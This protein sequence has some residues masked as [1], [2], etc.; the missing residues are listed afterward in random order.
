M[1]NILNLFKHKPNTPVQQIPTEMKSIVEPEPYVA[2]EI[3][4]YGTTTQ[5]E[6]PFIDPMA[7]IYE[8][9]KENMVFTMLDAPPL[10]TID[11]I[12][13]ST[14][15]G[16]SQ[17]NFNDTTTYFNSVAIL[18]S[19]NVGV[20]ALNTLT[21]AL[22]LTSSDLNTLSIDTFSANGTIVLNVPTIN[23]GV[24]KLNNLLGDL[25]LL[26]SNVSTLTIDPY[27]ANGTIVF[28]VPSTV[29]NTGVDTVNNLLG[30]LT[31]LSSNVS[32]L[33]VDSYPANSTI[34]FH[35]PSTV[36]NTG[37]DT[38]NNLL[39]DLTLLSSNVSTLT[40]DSYSANSTIVFHV[41]STVVNTG[42]DTINNI[43][44][45]I[46]LLSANVSTLSIDT[47]SANSTIVLKVPSATILPNDDWANYPA[48]NDV[49]IPNHDL[50]MT[51][52]TAGVS[53][54]TASFN[55]NFVIG[56]PSNLPLRPDMTAY[57]GTVT[58]GGLTTP[59]TGMNINSLGTVNINSL[60]GLSLLGGGGIT[61]AGAGAISA[62]GSTITLGAGA[63]SALG[64]SVDL[65]G[66]AINMAGGTINMA[67]GIINALGTAVN[68]GGGLITATTGGLLVTAGSVVVGTANIAGAGMVCYGGEIQTFP[69]LTGGGGGL[70]MNSCPITGVTTINGAAYP[71]AIGASYRGAWV[72]GTNYSIDDVVGNAS[73]NDNNALNVL[74][75]APVNIPNSVN[76]P[77]TAAG[78]TDGWI[79]YANQAIYGFNSG[80]SISDPN[81]TTQINM[82][83]IQGCPPPTSND[84][85]FIFSVLNNN[86]DIYSDFGAGRYIVAGINSGLTPVAGNTLP[87]I[88][89]TS[90]SLTDYNLEINSGGSNYEIN[91]I[92]KD[93]KLNG[94]PFDIGVS[95]FNTAT[96]AIDL[97]AADGIDIQPITS[98]SFGVA[99][100]G[101]RS[102]IVG[103]T[104]INN[105]G[106]TLVEGTNIE[107]IPSGGNTI[108]INN[109][110]SLNSSI[111]YRLLGTTA[112]AVIVN[113]PIGSGNAL[114][115][116]TFTLISQITFNLPATLNA[117]D[118]IYYDGWI[119]CDFSSN[120]NSFWGVSYYTNTV[121]TP[122]DI[123][124]ST[125]N[126]ANALNFSN[127][128]QIYLPLNL[129]MTTN[130]AA[131]GTITL[132]IY[133]NP[134]SN[135]HYLTVAP[136]NN[137]K[138]GIARD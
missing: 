57:C 64:G 111:P 112:G 58:F 96:G 74:F 83:A 95:S 1:D 69:S 91:F 127:I 130:I 115:I 4:T 28:H 103:A 14:F 42:V 68:V 80:D 136:I 110:Q 8:A 45:D 89:T 27:S 128:Q 43:L 7:E 38:V 108:T 61:I 26:S 129:I 82:N 137:A 11:M 34:V 123:L 10:T 67:G 31:L 102:L 24:D 51:T 60:T 9:S 75:I 97:L 100:T 33:T 131:G 135:N 92:A 40:I 125:T 3:I 15:T 88:T 44:G 71:P 48:I 78:Q 22:T 37:V 99:N 20:S 17:T 105:T 54:N 56:N 87:Y 59:L 81:F 12:Y 122:I 25:T 86:G 134:T 121:A 104:T 126:T 119:F 73:A 101:I 85:N 35:V 65:G 62:V 23:T 47:Y 107:L 90:T 124:G 41:P 72:S 132:Q 6:I 2:P 133:C 70:N 53:Y 30:D 63:V 5:Q 50:N 118:S 39:G 55:A 32:T 52:T 109:T 66:G 46:T 98:T 76:A 94:S 114:P 116:N 36:V 13:P 79:T 120:F 113:Q 106:V 29:V 77:W 49:I 18:P 19:P 84:G 21:G 16:V 117:G 93:L 138:I